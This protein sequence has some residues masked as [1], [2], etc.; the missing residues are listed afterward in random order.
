MWLDSFHERLGEIR[1]G[2]AHDGQ[3]Y[4]D[5]LVWPGLPHVLLPHLDHAQPVMDGFGFDSRRYWL[6]L[7]L[8]ALGG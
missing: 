1:P 8:L 6:A 7:V 4:L 5:D 3:F 2:V